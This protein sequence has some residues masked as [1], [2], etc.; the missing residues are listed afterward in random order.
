MSTKWIK[1]LFVVAGIFDTVLGAVSLVA[2]API[3]RAAGVTPP[4]HFG[5]IQFPA[6]LVII[7]GIMFFRIAANPV[8]RR[9]LIPYGMALKASYFGVVFW[10]QLTSG[11]PSLW[12]P[13]AWVDL[14]FFILFFLAWRSLA[15]KP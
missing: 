1:A 13:W 10:Y 3:F 11:V 8:A 2:S 12:I 5:Y 7:F 6:L 4:N 15:L 14:A 9:E